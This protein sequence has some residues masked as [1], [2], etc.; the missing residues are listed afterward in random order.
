M[1]LNSIYFEVTQPFRYFRL[2]GHSPS[3]TY[4]GRSQVFQ[5]VYDALNA[6]PGQIL[7]A[8]PGGLFLESAEGSCRMV[9]LRPPKHIF[10]KEYGP[11]SEK[12]HLRALE[13]DGLL[14]EIPAPA[15]KPDYAG[16]IRNVP[17]L[18]KNLH[19]VYEVEQSPQLTQF[20]EDMAPLTAVLEQMDGV[21]VLLPFDHVENPIVGL[22]IRV[23]GMN[24]RIE[25][26]FKPDG[27]RVQPHG[28]VL[29]EP[30]SRAVL[31]GWIKKDEFLAGLG[32]NVVAF[33]AR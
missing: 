20:L 6:Q 19:A 5:P 13:S 11:Y 18:A 14:T 8:I 10:E 28:N 9:A 21:D 33:P 3:N 4:V 23:G 30:F 16:T 12:D 7:H 29:P 26:A 1:I 24:A 2:R 31:N 27:Y 32:A 22:R 25:W 15:R 17:E